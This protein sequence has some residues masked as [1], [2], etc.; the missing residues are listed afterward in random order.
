MLHGRAENLFLCCSS[1]RS[2]NAAQYNET[3]QSV[4]G[5]GLKALLS[6]GEHALRLGMSG[7]HRILQGMKRVAG[8]RMHGDRQIAADPRTGLVA[9]H[10]RVTGGNGFL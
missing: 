9:K 1:L 6:A 4:A 2:L 10:R 7:K 3:L 8:E 5:A